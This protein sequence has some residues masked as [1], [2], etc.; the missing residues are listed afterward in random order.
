MDLKDQPVP[1]QIGASRR[2]HGVAFLAQLAERDQR[3]WHESK[4]ERRGRTRA[5]RIPK[6]VHD[7]EG[8][9]RQRSWWC[10][11]ES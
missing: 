2:D 4:T 6:P 7:G 11:R 3:R 1:E 5:S 9:L 10:Q 8:V